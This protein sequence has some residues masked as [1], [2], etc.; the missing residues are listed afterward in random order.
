MVRSLKSQA[1]SY[2][3][4]HEQEKYINSFPHFMATIQDNDGSK[5]DM[6]FMAM[7]SE[8]KDA[9]PIVMLHGWPGSFLEFLGVFGEFK[10]RHQAGDL[11]YHLIAPS[12][13][14]YG[15]T[16]DTPKTKDW[17]VAD[18][19]RLVN[20]LMVHLGFNNYIAQGGDIG[21]FTAQSLA[22]NH[23]ECKAIHG[24]LSES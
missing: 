1:N 2:I 16:S 24:K 8:K 20:K 11:P 14:G 15:F 4:R 10:K 18:N 13:V 19:A 5:F 7:F 9:V 22:N 12:L 6:H 21:S 23:K 3:C 17:H